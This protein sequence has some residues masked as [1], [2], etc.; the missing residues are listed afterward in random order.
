LGTSE[1]PPEMFRRAA[2]PE[3]TRLPVKDIF[4]HNY[5]A[6]YHYLANK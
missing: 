3:P 4:C 6:S 5:L 1:N 2:P